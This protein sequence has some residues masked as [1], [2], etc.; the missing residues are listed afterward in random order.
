MK[1][2]MLASMA[3]ADFAL[4]PGDETDRF[5][6]D[7]AL[8]IIVAGYAVPVVEKSAETATMKAAARER[9]G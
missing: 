4:S 6:D 7:E 9:R 5:G 3:G 8:R 2:R 1:I